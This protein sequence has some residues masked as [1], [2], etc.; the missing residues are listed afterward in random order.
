MDANDLVLARI[1]EWLATYDRPA[2][3]VAELLCDRHAAS[4]DR[5][6]AICE[7]AAGREARLSFAELRDRSVRFAGVLRELGVAKG[8][9][10]ATLLPKTPGTADHDARPF[11]GWA[12]STSRSS[13]RSGRRRSTIGSTTAGPASW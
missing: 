2:V 9:R 1:Q 7:D 5:V 3:A 13:R 4:P 6:A 12:R 8:D 10:V 11:G